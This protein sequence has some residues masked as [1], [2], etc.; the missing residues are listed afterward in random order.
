MSRH[1]SWGLVSTDPCGSLE[2]SIILYFLQLLVGEA[3]GN[4]TVEHHSLVVR[5]CKLEQLTDVNSNGK[6]R[7]AT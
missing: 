6:G 7:A 2:C 5:Q 4:C 3:M 1:L